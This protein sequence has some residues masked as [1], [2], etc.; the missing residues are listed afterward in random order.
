MTIALKSL[1]FYFFTGQAP[2]D[3]VL[4]RGPPPRWDSP[5][6]VMTVETGYWVIIPDPRRA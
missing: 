4:A 1:G 5:Q 6:T 3:D 2:V